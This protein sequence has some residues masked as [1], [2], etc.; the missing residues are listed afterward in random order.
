MGRW[1]EIWEGEGAR[2]LWRV[3]D[4]QLVEL[5]ADWKDRGDI[6][7][8]LD[9]GCG[10]G[11][12]VLHL[13]DLGFEVCGS[14]HS[15][16][17]IGTCREWLQEDGLEADVWCG[18]PEHIPQPDGFFDA[19]VA[20][21]SIYHG[22]TEEVE[23]AMRLIHAKLRPEGRC[24]ITLLSRRN[25]MYGKGEQ[26]GPDTFVSA[27]MFHQLFT[28]GGERG[29]PHHFS[30]EEEVRHFFEGFKIESL[31]HRELELPSSRTGADAGSFFKIPGAWFWRIVASRE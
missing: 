16:S 18:P 3:P 5:A 15:E 11:R 6:D 13:A 4:P 8:V 23:A 25:R 10:V 1:Q 29:V 9:H 17:A 31:D 21:N 28:H 19:V 22:K 24:F 30:S 2:R 27:G 20:F 7:R 14:D 12:H 26:I